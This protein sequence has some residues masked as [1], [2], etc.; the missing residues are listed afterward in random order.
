[1]KD[2]YFENY[3]TLKK[4]I[5]DDTNKWKD[6]PCTWTELTNIAKMSILPHAIYRFNTISIK[7]S[8]AF[9]TE[10]EQKMQKFV[11]K[12]ET[13]QRAKM[14]LNKNKNWRYN[15]PIF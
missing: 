9:F 7:I 14:V 5:E 8:T 3:K 13:P 6:I 1:M 10:L 15:N 4:E 11:G 12:H 2:L